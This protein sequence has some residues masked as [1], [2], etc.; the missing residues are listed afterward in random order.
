MHFHAFSRTTLLE[1]HIFQEK[2]ITENKV[3]YVYVV[4]CS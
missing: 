3:D 2:G 1:H 4:I